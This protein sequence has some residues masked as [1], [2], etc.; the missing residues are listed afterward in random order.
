[1]T[2]MFRVPASWMKETVIGGYR[3]EPLIN[4]ASVI[5][6]RVT[7]ADLFYRLHH[8]SGTTTD[9]GSRDGAIYAARNPDRIW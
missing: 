1:M 5:G 7:K 3:I 6:E 8:P 4:S 9:H 2:A